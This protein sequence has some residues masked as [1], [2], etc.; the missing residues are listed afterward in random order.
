MTSLGESEREEGVLVRYLLVFEGNV[1]D[2]LD[3]LEPLS[4]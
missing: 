4:L 2:V 1:A 3:L